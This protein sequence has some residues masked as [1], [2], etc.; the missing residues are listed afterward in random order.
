MVDRWDQLC[1]VFMPMGEVNNGRGT[2]V[3]TGGE[4]QGRPRWGAWD[5]GLGN[6]E[7][8]GTEDRT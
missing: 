6:F 4:S 2:M 1:S 5:I 8:E 7:R 3:G